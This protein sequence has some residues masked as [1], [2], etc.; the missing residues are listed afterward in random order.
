MELGKIGKYEYLKQPIAKGSFSIVYKGFYNLQTY[1]IKKIYKNESNDVYIKREVDTLKKLN[2]DNILKYYDCIEKNEKIYLI[3]EYCELDLDKFLNKRAL[4]EKHVK[5]I[6]TQIKNGLNYL[7][8]NNI[9]HRDLK[10]HNILLKKVN[11]EYLVK[12]CDFGL[13]KSKIDEVDHKTICGSPLYMAP[14]IIIKGKYSYQVDFWALGIMLYEMIYGT[15]PFVA[16]SHYELIKF[17]KKK[18]IVFNDKIKVSNECKDLIK[19]LLKIKPEDRYSWF[20]INQHDFFKEKTIFQNLF[21]KQKTE[22]TEIL[23]DI[24]EEDTKPEESK[25]IPIPKRKHSPIQF[26]LDDE[27][28]KY[29]VYSESPL[30]YDDNLKKYINMTPPSDVTMDDFIVVDTDETENDSLTK[31]YIWLKNSL[32]FNKFLLS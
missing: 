14:E 8:D 19:G 24:N 15:Q 25:A 31:T 6:F 16:K 32:G 28:M 9:I 12:I 20:E 26:E 22:Y 17:I 21:K 30:F 7:H 2:H 11:N 4:K 13:A 18:D 23:Y 10:P 27:E 5:N 3:V 1:A 29:E